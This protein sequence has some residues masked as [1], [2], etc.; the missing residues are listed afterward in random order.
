MVAPTTGALKKLIDEVA[1]NLDTVDG[2]RVYKYPEP[3]VSE[4]PVAIIRDAMGANQSAA[5]R[6]REGQDPE[7]VYYLEVLILVDQTDTEQAFA[8]LEK[9]MSNNSPSS[10]FDLMQNGLF[11]APIKDVHCTRAESRR[12]FAQWLEMFREV[13]SS[14][15][16][17]PSAPVYWGCTFWVEGLV[18]P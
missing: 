3:N 2:L 9:Y 13:T 6:Y 5:A 15:L 18:E 10:V 4:F 7:A 12:Q 11:T 1:I 8:E 17:E 16:R 14:S